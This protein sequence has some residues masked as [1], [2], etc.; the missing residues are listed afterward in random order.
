MNRPPAAGARGHDRYAVAMPD[1]DLPATAP[2]ALRLLG[3]SRWLMAIAVL[4]CLAIG[5]ALLAHTAVDTVRLIGHAL[6]DDGGGKTGKL[7]AIRAIELLDRYLI[8]SVA[9]ITAIGL[10]LLFV[11]DR[12]PVPA[13]LRIK[14]L[15]DLKD[16]LLH[17]IVVVITVLFVGQLAAWDGGLEIA[18]LGGA[19]A[20]VVAAIAAFVALAGKPKT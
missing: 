7:L 8:A 14:S 6:D 17:V 11:D 12:V 1:D 19:V 3:G 20:A 18:A 13:W 10:C 16:K 9:L 5:A 2:P 15:S 4:G